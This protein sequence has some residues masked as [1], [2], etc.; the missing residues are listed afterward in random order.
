MAER[1]HTTAQ[2]QGPP[3]LL[4]SCLPALTPEAALWSEVLQ[5]GP[6]PADLTH[7]S[8]AHVVSAATRRRGWEVQLGRE[9]K[10]SVCVGGYSKWFPPTFSKEAT[11]NLS[12]NSEFPM[13]MQF[14]DKLPLTSL[15][16]PPHLLPLLI[17]SAHILE[18]ATVSKAH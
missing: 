17:T 8:Q 16:P 15:S 4:R 13:Q 10:V 6:S 2:K 18:K 9:R 14:G 7:T 3:D 11:N 12:K 5:R 1:P